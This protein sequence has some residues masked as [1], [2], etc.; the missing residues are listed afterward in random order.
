MTL[1]ERKYWYSGFCCS[2]KTWNEEERRVGKMYKI[3]MTIGQKQCTPSPASIR[4][5]PTLILLSSTSEI[6]EG[7]PSTTYL[8]M[9]SIAEIQDKKEREV[10]KK[11]Q[12]TEQP[13]DTAPL[14]HEE[15]TAARVLQRTYRGHR[16]RRQLRGLS[17]DPS[18]RWTE[19]SEQSTPLLVGFMKLS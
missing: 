16:A 15:S 19:V 4:T 11:Y 13:Q 18:T 3:G 2:S 12:S 9:T 1:V 6:S 5:F 10:L 14:Q 8:D 17:L 7:F